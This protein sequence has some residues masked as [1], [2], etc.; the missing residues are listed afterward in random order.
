[1]LAKIISLYQKLDFSHII[2]FIFNRFIQEKKLR[3]SRKEHSCSLASQ[4]WLEF[5]E[6]TWFGK[7]SAFEDLCWTTSTVFLCEQTVGSLS[8]RPCIVW[9]LQPGA[10]LIRK[11][12]FELW[13]V[14]DSNIE[15]SFLFGKSSRLSLQSWR[16]GSVLYFLI[17]YLLV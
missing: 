17:V 16:I 5:E 7:F 8:D 14:L 13:R 11:I 3:K 2:L 6:S 15:K 4:F 12:T 9:L 1:M 10:V